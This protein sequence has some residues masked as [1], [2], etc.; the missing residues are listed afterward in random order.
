MLK[1]VG[2]RHLILL[3][4]V[5][6]LAL[7]LGGCRE[8]EQGRVLKFEQGKYLGKPDQSLSSEQVD[9]LRQRSRLQG[10]W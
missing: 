4:G 1:I 9:E 5:A 6:S 2:I 8:D 7:L 3:C 10:P